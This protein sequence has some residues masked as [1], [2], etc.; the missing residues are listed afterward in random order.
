MTSFCTLKDA[1]PTLA[2]WR[3][4]MFTFKDSADL[5]RTLEHRRDRALAA[6]TDPSNLV[7]ERTY[8]R[9]QY[10][11]YSEVLE[12]LRDYFRVREE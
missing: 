1:A 8:A 2:I 10:Y 4:S 3:T 12:L 11:V 6:S 5:I 7:R 9:G